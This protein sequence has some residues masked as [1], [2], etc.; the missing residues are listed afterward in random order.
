MKV[1]HIYG[2]SGAGTT[3]LAEVKRNSLSKI[4]VIAGI[5]RRDMHDNRNR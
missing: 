3:T 2:A 1:I 5:N 4:S